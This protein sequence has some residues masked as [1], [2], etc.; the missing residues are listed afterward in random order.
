MEGFIQIE[1]DERVI[2]IDIQIQRLK[3]RGRYDE[4][5]QIHDRFLQ[6]KPIT[7]TARTL[8]TTQ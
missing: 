3:F 7:L 5:A 8:T 6:F 4:V 2:Q 1:D